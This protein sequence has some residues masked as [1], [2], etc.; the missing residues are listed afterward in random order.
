MEYVFL[1]LFAISFLVTL[2]VTHIWIKIAKREKI[3]VKDMNKFG[4]P[5][6]PPSGGTSVIIGFLVGVLGYVAL[7][8]FYFKRV[9]NLVD[10]FAIL[11]TVLIISFIGIFDDFVCGWRKGFKR[12]QKPLLTFPAALPLMAINAGVSRIYIPFFKAVYT[13]FLFPLLIIPIGIVGAS[14]GFNMLA[15]LN[16]LEAGMGSI[17]LFTLGFLAWQVGKPWVAIIA[18]CAVFSLL[19]FLVYNKYPSKVFPGDVL[20]YP[21]GALI[22]CIAIVGNLERAALILFIPYFIELIIKAKNRLKSECFLIP[23]EDNSLEAPKKIGSLT[24]IIFK[25]LKLFKTKVYEYEIVFA[26]WIFEI[27]LAMIVILI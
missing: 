27:I 25:F 16:G 6:V 23:N 5:L 19:A 7:S 15:G 10:I 26:L 14:Q 13:G 24:H 18:C 3:L 4:Y 2:V 17:I 22:A 9:I 11:T 20:L 1:I 8:V 21:L 12:W